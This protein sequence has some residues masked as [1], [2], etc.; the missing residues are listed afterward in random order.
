VCYNGCLNFWL[1]LF[2]LVANM[3]VD[4]MHV[5]QQDACSTL[6]QSQDIYASSLVSRMYF[7]THDDIVFVRVSLFVLGR[8]SFLCLLI[9]KKLLPSLVSIMPLYYFCGI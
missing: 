5:T 6:H 9:M 2:I 1:L 8:R 7:Y 3:P 4:N